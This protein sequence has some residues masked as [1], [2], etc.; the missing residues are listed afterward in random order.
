M[1]IKSKKNKKRF[2]K[3]K[4]ILLILA[5]FLLIVFLTILFENGLIKNPLDKLVKKTQEINAK[6]LCSIIAGNII[7]TVS[8]EGECKLQCRAECETRN[9]EFQKSN[10]Q[11]IENDCNICTCYCN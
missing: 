2:L 10:F 8:D 1:P 5:I 6:D 3:N 9:L 4:H 7:H 11:L